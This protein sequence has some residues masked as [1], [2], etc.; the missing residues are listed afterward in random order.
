MRARQLGNDRVRTLSYYDKCQHTS[1]SLRPPV[2]FFV[3]AH[4]HKCYGFTI[5]R[6]SA[7]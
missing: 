4:Y 7:S 3:I 2:M 1:C 6:N 5:Q